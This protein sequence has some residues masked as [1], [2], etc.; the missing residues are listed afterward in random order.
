MGQIGKENKHVAHSPRQA[1]GHPP[2]SSAKGSFSERCQPGFGD[3]CP[4]PGDSDP[5]PRRC[6][7]KAL[8]N[9]ILQRLSPMHACNVPVAAWSPLRRVRLESS[10][11]LGSGAGSRIP[12]PA[13]STG[14]PALT[15]PQPASPPGPAR[16]LLGLV[17]PL[18][19]F[20][21]GV[22]SWFNYKS[23]SAP[24][25]PDLGAGLEAGARVWLCL[26][27]GGLFVWLKSLGS[28]RGLAG[29]LLAAFCEFRAIWCFSLEAR[30]SFPHTTLS[31][32][33][34]RT[35]A[36]RWCSPRPKF[37]HPGFSGRS[38]GAGRK[39]GWGGG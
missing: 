22:A 9:R 27:L 16:W 2:P 15:H 5:A 8:H 23:H 6:I 7:T 11:L 25:W 12:A 14:P 31:P 3:G 32:T 13:R 21:T 29:A 18:S 36:E 10:Q 19:F 30:R 35:P 1:R 34:A 4:S 33:S 17:V 37:H 20:R 24:R 26:G 28:R 38:T 39:Q